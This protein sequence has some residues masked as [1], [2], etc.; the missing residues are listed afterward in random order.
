MFRMSAGAVLFAIGVGLILL[1]TAVL[2]ATTPT[3]SPGP[4][5]PC[6]YPLG[7]S[8]TDALP[9]GQTVFNI[10]FGTY[11]GNSSSGQS[12]LYDFTLWTNSSATYAIYL[13]TEDQYHAVTG[14]SNGTV[15]SGP[16]NGPPA[17]YYWT[18]GPVERYVYTG[19]FGLSS[20]MF[21]F[22]DPGTAPANLTLQDASCPAS[23]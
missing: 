9:A 5:A 17:M 12:A 21:G 14:Y 4:P 8:L 2:A 13:L 6:P 16:I 23:S 7:P 18:S 1:V 15:G 19:T 10:Q 11:V 3:V 22:Y 20:W